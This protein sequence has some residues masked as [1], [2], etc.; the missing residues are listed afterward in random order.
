MKI[1]LLPL[2]FE[3]EK[4]RVYRYEFWENNRHSDTYYYIRRKNQKY[5]YH[6]WTGSYVPVF[7]SSYPVR[8]LLY[9]V[10]AM[11]EFGKDCPSFLEYLKPLYQKYH[12]NTNTRAERKKIAQQFKK[13]KKS[14]KSKKEF[15]IKMLMSYLKKFDELCK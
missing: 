1:K 11:Q 6:F 2:L 3:T 13:L 14:S 15:E 12:P 10:R 4:Y 7:G 9:Q 5:A 8:I